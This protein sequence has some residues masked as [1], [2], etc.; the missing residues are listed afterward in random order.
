MNKKKLEE[1]RTEAE[2]AQWF[3]KNQDR[4]L[5]FFQQAQKDGALRIGRK[6]VGITLSKTTGALK[7]PSQGDAAHS[8]RRPESRP[9]PGGR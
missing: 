4:L 8:Q 1:T 6:T 2:E 5:K 3:E 9:A 7:P